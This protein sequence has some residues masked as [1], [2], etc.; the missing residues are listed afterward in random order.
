[1]TAS[2]IR[3]ESQTVIQRPAREVFDRLADLTAYEGWMH[4]DG[5]FRR[6]ASVS[7]LPVREGTTYLDLTW[8][9][10]FEGRVDE[11][12]P[13]S[14]LAF[15]ET[16][17]WFG[18]ALTRARPAYVLEPDGDATVV[19]H[20]AVGELYGVMKPFRPVARWLADRERTRTL[21]SL[22]RSLEG[23]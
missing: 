16:L 4:H 5:L 19:H 15:S 13:P 18:V 8:M 20:T 14:R 11:L 3:F 1:M 6:C 23:R 12:V 21:A 17:S 2:T 9:G 22:K 7:E 10:R